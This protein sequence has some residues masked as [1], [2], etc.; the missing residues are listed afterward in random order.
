MP[1]PDKDFGGSDI[2]P[3]ALGPESGLKLGRNA[4]KWPGDCG[5]TR[6]S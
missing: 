4:L 5:Q 2:S 1:L 6:R 3:K